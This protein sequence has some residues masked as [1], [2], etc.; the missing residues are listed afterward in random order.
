MPQIDI[1]VF[2]ESNDGVLQVTL[3]DADLV[4][5]NAPLSAQIFTSD[6]SQSIEVV[7]LKATGVGSAI[8]TGS[9]LVRAHTGVTVP[10]R[11]SL[12]DSGTISARFH[13]Q[14]PEAAVTVEVSSPRPKLF[15]EKNKHKCLF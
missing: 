12:T 8:F 11:I 9:I 14:F 13:D 2:F 6:S 15:D 7:A 5:S 3:S 10:G 1:S 4:D